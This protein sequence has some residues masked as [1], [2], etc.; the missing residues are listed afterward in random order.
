MKPILKLVV[1]LLLTQ[2]TT[3]QSL[4]YISVKKKNGRT[5]KNVYAGS[6]VLLQ[7]VQGTY[8]QGPVESIRNDSLYLT[9]YDVRTYATV[10]GT[11]MRDTISRYILGLHYN[12]IARIHLNKRLSFVER[13]GGTLLMLG[14]GGY[15]AV[16]VLNGA[17]FNEPITEKKNLTKLGIAVGTFGLGYLMNKLFSTDGFSKKK[18]QIVYVDL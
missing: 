4:D 18:H 2:T 10:W 17:F 13:T 7:T 3:A 8:W 16:N 9:I 15:F 11:R 12:E 1:L 6:T 5:V 14:G